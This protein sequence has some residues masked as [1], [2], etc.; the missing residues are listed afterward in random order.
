MYEYATEM[1]YDGKALGKKS[2]RDK[3]LKRL[4]KSPAVIA[5]GIPTRFLSENAGELCDR[6]G[7]LLQEKQ[8]G[9]NSD[10]NN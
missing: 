6:F 5:S 10:T 9:N 2:T 1:Y 7:L 4:L 8:A 3:L